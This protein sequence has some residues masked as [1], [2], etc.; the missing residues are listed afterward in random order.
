[1]ESITAGVAAHRGT[2]G[3]RR[4]GASRWNWEVRAMSDL[5]FVYLA[6]NFGHLLWFAKLVATACYFGSG[7][8]LSAKL[9]S[10]KGAIHEHSSQK[11]VAIKVGISETRLCRKLNPESD[12][13]ANLRDLDRMDEEIQREFHFREVCRLGLPLRRREALKI[14]RVIQRVRRSA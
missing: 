11:A 13:I 14:A 8:V 1:V 9:D 4:A 10:L 6:H 2:R 5:L 7:L 12:G 3:A